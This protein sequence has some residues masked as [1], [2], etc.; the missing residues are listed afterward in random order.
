[1]E[2]A[3][4]VLATLSLAL[5]ALAVSVPEVQARRGYAVWTSEHAGPVRG[6]LG[7]AGIG[8]RRYYCDYQRHP[9]RVCRASGGK[10]RCRVV[11]WTLRQHCY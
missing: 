7:F 9:N 6:Y 4:A 10:E 1:M 3:R 11:S 5:F 2:P 8:P